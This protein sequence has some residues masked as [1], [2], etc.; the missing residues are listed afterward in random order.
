VQEYLLRYGEL[1]LKGRN[2]KLFVQN[3]IQVL[4]PRLSVLGGTY[5]A[6]HKKLL[7]ATDAP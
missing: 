1:T 2:R 5:Q 3:L 7:V 6:L 4:K